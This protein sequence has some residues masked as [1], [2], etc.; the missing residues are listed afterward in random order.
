MITSIRLQNFKGH[1]DTTVPLGRMT[2]LVGPNGAG[3]TS[4]LQALHLLGKLAEQAPRQLLQDE[5]SPSDLLHRASQGPMRFEASGTNAGL[6]W[7]FSVSM[8]MPE[9]AAPQPRDW[10]LIFEWSPKM[11]P[12]VSLL[13]EPRS[14]TDEPI[15]ALRPHYGP[16]VLYHFDARQIAAAAYSGEENPDVQSDG[17]NVAVVLAALKLEHEEVFSQI[18]SELCRIVPSVQRIRV[19][20]AKVAGSSGIVGHKIIFDFHNAPDIPAHG[21]SE[22]TLVT[23]ALLTALF[24]PN[25]PRLLLLDDIDQSLH[26]EAQMQLVRELKQLLERFPDVQIVATTHSPYILDE[27]APED[28]QAFVQRPGGGIA[29]K[30]LSEHPQAA[31]MR[32]ALT[33]GQ[34]WSLDP[35]RRWVLEEG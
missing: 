27:L 26:P 16:A 3:K 31:Q 21:A 25:R 29:S 7:G 30:R 6:Y 23:L 9:P 8:T 20:R 2:V 13:L 17:G 32:G 33:A 15:S 18:E 14:I 12:L 5:W 35:E 10:G 19:R 34:L 28:V 4:V 24:N 22:G 11:Q 1:R